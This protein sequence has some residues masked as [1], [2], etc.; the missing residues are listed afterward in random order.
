MHEDE[1]DHVDLIFRSRSP[2][3][4][5]IFAWLLFR[6]RLNTRA[7]LFHMSLAQMLTARAIQERHNTPYTSSSPVRLL[8]RFGYN[9]A[10]PHRDVFQD[11]WLTPPAGLDPRV[12]PEVLLIILWKIWDT[13]NADIFKNKGHNYLLTIRN[14]RNDLELCLHRFG[15]PVDK[16]ATKSWLDYFSSRLSVTL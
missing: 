9:M 7:N 13:R 16:V 14:I 8:L 2:N 15:D 5:K 3:K 1:D 12:W 11:L 10:S 4:I 6:G